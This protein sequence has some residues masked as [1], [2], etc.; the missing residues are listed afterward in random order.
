MMHLCSHC[1]FW[2]H[3]TSSS[4]FQNFTPLEEMRTAGFA[5]F[6]SSTKTGGTETAPHLIPLQ[7]VFGVQ[8]E[9]SL[10]MSVGDI[11][12]LLVSIAS[13]NTTQWDTVTLHRA[14]SAGFGFRAHVRGVV[15]KMHFPYFAATEHWS[16]DHV[17]GAYYQLNTQSVLTWA[18]ADTSCKQQSASLLSV[19]D[20]IEQ[21][22]VSGK[23]PH[24]GY[25]LGLI[26]LHIACS[27]LAKMLR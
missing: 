15:L 13:E 1:I 26:Q 23:V 3:S 25:E 16:Q 7:N 19:S 17:T 6:L 20:P 11:A 14:H 22:H 5:C 12:R 18:Q 10:K 9:Q 2:L 4:P 24:G 21:S 27:T 8:L